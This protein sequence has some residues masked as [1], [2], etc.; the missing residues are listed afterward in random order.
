M[1]Q[2]LLTLGAVV[3]ILVV[4]FGGVVIWLRGLKR[5][6]AEEL[7][8]RLAA[9]GIRLMDESANC[10]GL[11]SAGLLQVRGNGCLAATG[12]EIEFLMWK[13]RK[14]FLI[15]RS[16]ILGVESARSHLGKTKGVKLLKVRFRNEKG[17]PDSIAW[18][19]RELDAWLAELAGDASGADEPEQ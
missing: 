4:V 17:E 19:V 8:H 11:E 14:A 10:L 9:R 13:P 6:V 18:A 1:S 2:V 7:R 12:H 3:V 5:S 15:P 16:E